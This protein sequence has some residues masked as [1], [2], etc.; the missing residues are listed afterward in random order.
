MLKNPADPVYFPGGAMFY[1]K[2]KTWIERTGIF[3]RR[4]GRFLKKEMRN[5]IAINLLIWGI[6][7]IG[8]IPVVR[9]RLMK[10]GLSRLGAAID[11]SIGLRL[12]G[13]RRAGAGRKPAIT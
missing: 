5:W 7:R 2:E 3:N 6:G 9:K 8:E 13:R 11:S 10:M 12:F 1:R 4:G